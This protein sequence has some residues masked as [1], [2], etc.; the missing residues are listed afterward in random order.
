LSGMQYGYSQ[1]QVRGEGA[2]L[3]SVRAASMKILLLDI[4]TAPNTAYIWGLYDQNVGINQLK[5]SSYILCYAAKWL[6][7]REIEWERGNGR[8]RVGMLKKLHRLL[9]RADAVIHFNGLRFDIPTVNKEFISHHMPQPSPYKQ[10]DLLRVVKSQFRFTSNKLDYVCQ[11]LGLGKKLRHAGQDLWTGCMENDP[12]SWRQMEQ[13]NRQDVRIM[14]R[15][16]YRLLP[17]MKTHAN[18]SL[19]DKDRAEIVCPNCGES[20]YQRRGKAYTQTRTYHKFQCLACKSWFRSV[21]SDKDQK[22][23]TVAL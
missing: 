18:Y 14:E 11:A 8:Y 23:S 9:S 15:L 19:F 1:Y 4:E 13:Y 20:A 7:D 21:S 16:Y 5:E 17:W 2:S 3:W 6:G 22:A 12:R 10:M